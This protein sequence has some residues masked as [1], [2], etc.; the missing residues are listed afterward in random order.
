LLVAR[1]VDRVESLE[2][3]H[4]QD[5]VKSL[6]RWGA[7]VINNQVNIAGDTTNFTVK[8]TRPDLSVCSQFELSL[9]KKEEV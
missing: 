3:S 5:E 9:V 1:V 2:E 7:K 8:G 6:S 4:A